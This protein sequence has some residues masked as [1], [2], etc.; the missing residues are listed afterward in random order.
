[1]ST[2]TNRL[3]EL[4]YITEATR[5]VMPMLYSKDRNA[6]FF[7]TKNFENCYIGD[8]NHPELDRKIFLLYNYKISAE[9]IKTENA[10]ML[11]PEFS[12]DYDYSDERQVMYTFDIPEIYKADFDLFIAGD[13]ANLSDELKKNIDLF[14]GKGVGKFIDDEHWPKPVL[15]REI[16]M[17]PK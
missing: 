8:A 4:D 17:N 13:Y 3:I 2:V 9:F 16:Y 11:I 7:I 14:W 5:F 6:H 15:T 12:T 10:L 1:M